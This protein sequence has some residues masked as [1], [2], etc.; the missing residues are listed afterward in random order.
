V[1]EGTGTE[2]KNCSHAWSR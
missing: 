2:R 1:R